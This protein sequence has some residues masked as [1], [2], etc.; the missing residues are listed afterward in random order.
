MTLASRIQRS[1]WASVLLAS[2]IAFGAGTAFA[3]DSPLDEANAL[4]QKAAAALKSAE[5][6]GEKPEAAAHRKKA[7]ELIT[8]AQSEIL[9][10]KQ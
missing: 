6:G 2:I 3:A 7:V 5:S 10:A 9:K 1:T 8:R 4:L